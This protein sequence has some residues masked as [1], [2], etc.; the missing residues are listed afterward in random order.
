[1]VTKYKDMVITFDLKTI[2]EMMQIDK[3]ETEE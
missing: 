3:N 2:S 1:M